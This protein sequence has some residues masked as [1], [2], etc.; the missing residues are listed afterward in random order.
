VPA[1]RKVERLPTKKKAGD[2]LLSAQVIMA[3]GL[4]MPGVAAVTI[5]GDLATPD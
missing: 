3:F 1:K 5:E 4:A 2:N